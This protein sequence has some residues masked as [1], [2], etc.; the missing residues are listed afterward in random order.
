[1]DHPSIVCTLKVR[2]RRAHGH[3]V[4]SA[5]ITPEIEALSQVTWKSLH[6]KWPSSFTNW[7]KIAKFC[8]RSAL[9]SSIKVE[10]FRIKGS[11]ES[12]LM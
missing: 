1:M 4:L 6:N 2:G 10:S 5:H 9:V 11:N 12:M 7:M 3:A 8:C